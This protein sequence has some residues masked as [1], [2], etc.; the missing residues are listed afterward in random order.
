MTYRAVLD[1]S[2]Y[3]AGERIRIGCLE[4]HILG[5][6]GG[7]ECVEWMHVLDFSCISIHATSSFT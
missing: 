6:G 2:S 5:S 7:V 1:T 4:I 3:V